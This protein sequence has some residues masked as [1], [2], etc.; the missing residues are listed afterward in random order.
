MNVSSAAA[1]SSQGYTTL[2][3]KIELRTTAPQIA[4]GCSFKSESQRQKDDF[5]ALLKRN[6]KR[7]IITGKIEKNAAKAPFAILMPPLQSDSRLSAANRD[8]T[9]RAAGATRNLD[10]AIPLRSS[11]TELQNTKEWQHTTVEHI[12]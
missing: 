7:E 11:D 9:T 12:L 1:R 6:S 8:S 5:A 3:C 2:S 4:A 10:A